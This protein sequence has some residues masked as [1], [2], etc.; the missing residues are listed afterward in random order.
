MEDPLDP[1]IILSTMQAHGL[2]KQ[3]QKRLLFKALNLSV[4]PGMC[5][6]LTGPSGCGKTILMRVLAGLEPIEEGHV[7]CQGSLGWMLQ[8]SALFP[9]MTLWENIIYAPLQANKIGKKEIFLQANKWL[10]RFHLAKQ[11]AYYPNALSG[12]E[13]QRTALIRLMMV[14]P[15]V[16]MLDEPTSAL[17]QKMTNVVAEVIEEKK[18]QGHRY[19]VISHDQAFLEKIVDQTLTLGQSGETMSNPAVKQQSIQPPR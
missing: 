2:T 7:K 4:G 15:N 10:A 11:K 1:T 3:Y 12:G 16:A 13:A 5:L 17:D 9:H 8:N 19:I 14:N 6:G 18:Y